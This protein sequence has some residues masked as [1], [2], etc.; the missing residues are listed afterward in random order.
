MKIEFDP[1]DRNAC[2]AVIASIHALHPDIAGLPAGAIVGTLEHRPDDAPAGDS[3]NA[4]PLAVDDA[5]D[6]AAAFGSPSPEAAFAGNAPDAS[7]APIAAGAITP[8]PPPAPSGA[9]ELDADGLPWDARIHSGP[10][11]KRPKNG[12][13]RW[14]RKPRVDDATVHAV[15]AE[16]R[17]VMGAPAPVPTQ[18][19]PPP[20]VPTAPPAPDPVTAAPTGAPPAPPPTP[21]AAVTESGPD[22]A[23]P[24]ASGPPATFADLMR[25]VTGLQTAGKLTI[26]DTNAI[27]VGLGLTGLRD[28]LKRPDLV[29]SFY[30]LLPVA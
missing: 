30:Q 14:R 10:V 11:D 6:P 5:P 9:V 27:A 22:V 18:A 12:D 13:G 23:T 25:V 16:L 15:T 19:A 21:A 24:A 7:P 28:V 20:P 3:G 29:P 17:Q 26:E 4:W 8:T 1:R 2:A